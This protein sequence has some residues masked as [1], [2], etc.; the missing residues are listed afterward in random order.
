M[1]NLPAAIITHF[2]NEQSTFWA[3][4]VWDAFLNDIAAHMNTSW[5]QEHCLLLTITK[6]GQSGPWVGGCDQ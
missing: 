3:R 5:L 2:F 1:S 4:C 6:F